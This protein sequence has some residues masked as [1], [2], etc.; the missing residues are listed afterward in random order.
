MLSLQVSQVAMDTC[1]LSMA[2]DQQPDDNFQI[3]EVTYC[4]ILYS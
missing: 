2:D 3:P 1:D 4:A